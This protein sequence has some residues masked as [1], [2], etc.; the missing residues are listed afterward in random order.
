MEEYMDFKK[1]VME[2]HEYAKQ[3]K[4]K[5][6]GKIL[7]YFET[8]FPEEIAYA[9]GIL[10]VRMLARHEPDNISDK[11]IYASC[12]PV[13]DI[14]NQVLKGQYDYI[15]GLVN[16]EGCQW[17]F[18]AFEVTV[19]NK[20]DVFSHYLYLP[21]YTDALT[22]KD[23]LHSELEVF[24]G[25]LEKW[26][27]KTVTNEA[28]DHA[29]EVYNTTR[30]HLRRICELRR[31]DRPVL[32]G[33]E[34]MNI[35]LACQLMDKAEVN[36]LLEEYI[37]ELEDRVP[38]EDRIRLMLIG[39]E[40]FD[41]H[42]EEMVEALGGNIVVDELDNGTSYYWNEAIPQKDRLMALSLRYLGRPHNPIKDNNWRRRTQHI[43]ELSE[44]FHVDGVIIAKQIY[45]HLHGT[46]NYAVWKL[47]RERNIPFHFFERDMVLPEEE[48][49]LRLEAFMNMLRPGLTRLV[50]WHKPLAI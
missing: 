50:G 29:I 18:N 21:D 38:G 36:K 39:S 37:V 19:N 8:Y 49:K 40:T 43:F 4:E 22:S 23:V 28:L 20:P 14:V 30:R 48:T 9:A 10:P 45:C 7:G 46:D 12:Y 5:T 15:D 32:T 34:A 11:W 47:L 26:T 42:L 33:S 27:G 1:L 16:V 2:R 44:D 6:G 3:W 31:A 25:R 13:K 24:Q 41:T 17:M 35:V